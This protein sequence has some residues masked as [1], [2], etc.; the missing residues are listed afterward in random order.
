MAT[1]FRKCYILQ[2]EDSSPKRDSNPRS[3]TGGRLGKQ[4]CYPLHHASPYKHASEEKSLF[5]QNND[6]TRGLNLEKFNR[7]FRVNSL[8][9]RDRGK[10]ASIFVSPA[11][12]EDACPLGHELGSAAVCFLVGWLP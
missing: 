7:K 3:S 1:S 8:V 11:F 5:L 9:G 6:Q 12:E 10:R 4:T 2:P